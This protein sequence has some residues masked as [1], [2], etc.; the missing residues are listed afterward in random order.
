MN[1]KDDILLANNRVIILDR[2]YAFKAISEIQM[3][4]YFKAFKKKFF[5]FLA[6]FFFHMRKCNC[7]V[8]LKFCFIFSLCKQTWKNVNF[9]MIFWKAYIYIWTPT[10]GQAKAGRP[11]RTYMLQLWEDT[12]CSPEDLPEAMNDREKWWQGVRDIRAGVTS[13]WYIYIYT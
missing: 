9:Y 5:F 8:E 2:G 3:V 1:N 7:C 4:F 11:A 10:Y 12:G 13:W 6:I